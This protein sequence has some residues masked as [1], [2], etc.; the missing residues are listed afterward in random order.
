MTIA[1]DR[2][3][4]ARQLTC[5]DAKTLSLAILNF[6]GDDRLTN[7]PDRFMSQ[8]AIVEQAIV[9]RMGFNQSRGQDLTWK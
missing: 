5:E 8:R 6:L 3:N 2:H 1:I 4:S 9:V 7:S